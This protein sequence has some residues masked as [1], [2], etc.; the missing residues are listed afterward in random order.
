MVPEDWAVARQRLGKHIPAATNIQGDSNMTGTDLC[1]NKPHSVGHIWTTLYINTTSSSSSSSYFS[2]SP[3]LFFLT[4]SFFIIST[5]RPSCSVTWPAQLVV[6]GLKGLPW[7][8]IYQYVVD[9]RSRDWSSIPGR[10]IFYSI[11]VT[12]QPWGHPVSILM[13]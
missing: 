11:I 3:F 9:Y 6:S 7:T 10:N 13:T 8:V 5:S 2:L 12:K 4:L 1:A